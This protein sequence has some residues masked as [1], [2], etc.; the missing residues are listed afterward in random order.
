MA[1]EDKQ[2]TDER[3]AGRDLGALEEDY[4]SSG[5]G[6]KIIEMNVS[7]SILSFLVILVWNLFNIL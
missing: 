4:W 7:N 3:P 6:R 2:R 1:A 5:D